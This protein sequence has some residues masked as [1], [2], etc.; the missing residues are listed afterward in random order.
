MPVLIKGLFISP[1]A[2]G[3]FSELC[4]PKCIKWRDAH[5]WFHLSALLGPAKCQVTCVCSRRD[6]GCQPLG[7]PHPPRLDFLKLLSQRTVGHSAL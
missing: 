1:P 6:G 3:S 5:R 7:I 2:S 4:S